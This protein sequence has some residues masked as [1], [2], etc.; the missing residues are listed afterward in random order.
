MPCR[1]SSALTAQAQQSSRDI[2]QSY[3]DA[4]NEHDIAGILALVT[5]DIRW[6]AVDGIR[7]R[8][9]SAGK[10]ALG[11]G[12]TAYFENL[13]SARSEAREMNVLGNFVVVIEEAIWESA[14]VTNSQ[15]AISVYE[16]T[17]GL[18]SN[19]WYY[20]AQPCE[21]TSDGPD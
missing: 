12:I 14:G 6:M 10:E 16:I 7:M 13:P 20:P 2:V 21:P 5:H 4:Y 9:Q 19:V 18:I 1:A 3:L 8:L 15:C 17:G 11:D